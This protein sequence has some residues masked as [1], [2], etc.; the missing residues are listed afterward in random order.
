MTA[1]GELLFVYGSLMSDSGHPMAAMLAAAAEPVGSGRF[2]GRKYRVDW[3]CGA[4]PSVLEEDVVTGEVYRL[5]D[6]TTLLR[7]L[8]AY[9][10]AEPLWPAPA[11]YRR[12][13]RQVWMTQE[14]S[15]ADC[16]IYLYNKPVAALERLQ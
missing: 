1:A 15:S 7:L 2:Q 9:E 13:R 5:H 12:E 11:E 14:G 8:D 16:W 6:A 3:Y 4:V 10:E